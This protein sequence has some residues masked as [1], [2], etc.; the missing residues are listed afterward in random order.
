MTP[1]LCPKHEL[2]LA[3]CL[4][5]DRHPTE[6]AR[7]RLRQDTARFCTPGSYGCPPLHQETT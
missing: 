5:W 2:I 3:R 7:D 1:R 4:A 6:E